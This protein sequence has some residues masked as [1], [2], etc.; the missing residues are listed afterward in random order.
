MRNFAS[1]SECKITLYAMEYRT[2]RQP[3]EALSYLS[4]YQL[5][6]IFD[7]TL[8]ML[9]FNKQMTHSQ[10]PLEQKYCYSIW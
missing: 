1:F 5:I 3:N 10:I 4:I 6:T 2:L 7:F 9:F 8:K